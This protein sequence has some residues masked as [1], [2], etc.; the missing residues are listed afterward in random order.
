MAIVGIGI[1]CCCIIIIIIIIIVW[2]LFLS[3][4][5]GGSGGSGYSDSG[6]YDDSGNN[7][8]YGDDYGQSGGFFSSFY[9]TI[10]Q[11][12]LMK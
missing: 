8:D 4:G 7:D 9:P 1:C 3:G 6:N 12:R 10:E 5:S 11:I 2:K